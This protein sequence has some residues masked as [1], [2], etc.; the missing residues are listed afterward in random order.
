[1]KDLNKWRDTPY[2]W[3]ERFNIILRTILAKVIYTLEIP[4]LLFGETCKS[5][6]SRKRSSHC[7][8]VVRNTASIHEDVC[9][10]PGPAQWVKDLIQHCCELWYRLQTWLGSGVAV[11]VPWAG[12]CSSNL[13]PSLG[14][15]M[16]CRCTPKNHTKK[17]KIKTNYEENS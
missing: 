5:K 14:T 9:S 6:T 13:I 17:I 1:M 2:A 8:S 11:T 12:S 16:C 7:D 10:I 3:V 15:S 4:K